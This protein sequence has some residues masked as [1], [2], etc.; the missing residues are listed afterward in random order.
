MRDTQAASEIPAAIDAR[1]ARACSIEQCLLRHMG[2]YAVAF[3]KGSKDN[4][5]L[6][7]EMSDLG[8]GGVKLGDPRSNAH[9]PQNR[10]APTQDRSAPPQPGG[11]NGRE[12]P[13]YPQSE[14]ETTSDNL[15]ADN[16]PRISQ[17]P[18]CSPS[19]V[20]KR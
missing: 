11:P 12:G 7:N 20:S 17:A 8:G 14:K 10:S 3:G 9:P 13:G 16:S 4:H 6:C 18:I 5:I 19:A 2:Q 15:V 1:G